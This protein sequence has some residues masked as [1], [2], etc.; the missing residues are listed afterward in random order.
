MIRKDELEALGFHRSADNKKYYY[1]PGW[2]IWTLEVDPGNTYIKVAIQEDLNDGAK[3]SKWHYVHTI[4]GLERYFE[5]Y[6]PVN[7][8]LIEKLQR[9]LAAPYEP[10]LY[11]PQSY[12]Y[13]DLRD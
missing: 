6:E 1:K 7:P 8:N 5:R 13:P 3:D 12:H 9:S 10:K 4:E 2:Q 11:N